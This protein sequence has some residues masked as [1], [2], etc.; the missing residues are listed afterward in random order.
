MQDN[1]ARFRAIQIRAAA[2]TANASGRA[3]GDMLIELD[4]LQRELKAAD[5]ARTDVYVAAVFAVVAGFNAL[6]RAQKMA[7]LLERA[8]DICRDLPDRRLLRR[9]LSLHG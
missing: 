2:L 8:I 7:P 9:A 3:A 6:G 4:G 1:S 5:T